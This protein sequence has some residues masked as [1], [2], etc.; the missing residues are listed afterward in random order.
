MYDLRSGTSHNTD[1]DAVLTQMR[2][3]TCIT[4]CCV[5]ASSHLKDRG[6]YSTDRHTLSVSG[7]PGKTERSVPG[8]MQL[9]RMP[10]CPSSSAKA[11]VKD[12]KA[13]LLTAYRA[14]G[15][16]GT[17]AVYEEIN[18]MLPPC[19]AWPS[20]TQCG[21]SRTARMHKRVTCCYRPLTSAQRQTLLQVGGMVQACCRRG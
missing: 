10:V 7:V 13:V 11:F 12:S 18:T 17:Y 20:A 1:V 8:A 3:S 5:T 15:A 6:C 4:A 14:M 2:L 19:P 21:T 9:T 16:T